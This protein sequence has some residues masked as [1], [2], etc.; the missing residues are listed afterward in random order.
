MPFTN[1]FVQLTDRD[2]TAYSVAA[3]GAATATVLLVAPVSYH[4][5]AFRKGRKPE[6]VNVASQLAQLGLTAFGIA[7]VA[8]SF[9]IADVVRG[10]AWAIGFSGLI[11]VLEI[12]LWY[13]LP[14]THPR[15][16]P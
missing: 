10:L 15:R 11:G 1:R 2:I 14:L 16:R 7:L 4:R 12:A 3:V 9:L 8:A 6:L 5:L 13:A